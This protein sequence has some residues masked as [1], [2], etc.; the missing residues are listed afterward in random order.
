VFSGAYEHTVD[1][2]GRTVI[3]IG[4]RQRLGQTLVVTRGMNGC[5]WLFGDARWTEVQKTFSPA[6]L[7][8]LRGIKLE[9]YFLGGAHELEP[10][11]QG[12]VPI[13]QILM[14]HAGISP[15]STIWIV[16]LMDRIEI[17]EK[18]RWEAFNA[19]VAEEL[20]SEVESP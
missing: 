2:K 14:D 7:L 15:G 20:L 8:D 16:G 4:M 18:S 17:W 11:K 5:L 12:R 1:D 19:E 13:P 3:P 10:D 6:S 9:R